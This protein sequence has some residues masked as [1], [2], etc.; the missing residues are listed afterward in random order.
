MKAVDRLLQ[1]W[2]IAKARSYI[3]PH[4]RVLDIGCAD[5]ALFDQLKSRVGEGVGID[6]DLG[7]SV[8]RGHYRLI[9]GW[10]PD[11]LPDVGPFDAITL[12]AVLE[13]V[14][15]E[16]LSQLAENCAR[17]LKPGGHLI[18]TVPSPA[19]DWILILLKFIRIIDGMSL[20][21]HYGFEPSEAPLLFAVGGLELV[22]VKKFQLGLNNLYVFQKI[23][24]LAL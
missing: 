11:D 8:D 14:P 19:V 10:F 18:I 17:Y 21:E 16:Q 2:R 9:A 7:Q 5:G 6:P 4:A 20:E 24:D 1:R 12:L 22:K 15:A 23:K 3:V 13:H